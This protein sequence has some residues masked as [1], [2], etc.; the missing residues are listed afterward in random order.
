MKKLE[1][2][3]SNLI[4]SYLKEL[5]ACQLDNSSRK[6]PQNDKA[7]LGILI[8][9]EQHEKVELVIKILVYYKSLIMNLLKRNSDIKSDEWLRKFRFYYSKESGTV[10]IKVGKIEVNY[11]FQ[12]Y[13][14]TTDNDCQSFYES[15][16]LEKIL[17]NLLSII[18]NKS[19]PLL[20]GNKV[21]FNFFL[22]KKS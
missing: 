5:N 17:T 12:Y 3:I 2:K 13:S 8:T 22:N 14:L 7:N 18:T 15:A 16:E 19:N 6:S 9:K 11:G 20:H 4:Q 1:T 21:C 10:V